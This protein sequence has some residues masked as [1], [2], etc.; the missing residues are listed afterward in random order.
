M[1][2]SA[3]NSGKLNQLGIDLTKEKLTDLSLTDKKS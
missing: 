1:T 2:I 3:L